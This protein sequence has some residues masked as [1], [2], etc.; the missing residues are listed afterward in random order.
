VLSI[1]IPMRMK[2]SE[3]IKKKPPTRGKQQGCQQNVHPPKSDKLGRLFTAVGQPSERPSSPE[4]SSWIQGTGRRLRYLA[5][6]EKDNI[7]KESF[8]VAWRRVD[9]TGRSNQSNPRRTLLCKPLWRTM[10]SLRHVLRTSH[11]SVSLDMIDILRSTYHVL[12][13]F[14]GKARENAIGINA[15]N[16]LAYLPVADNNADSNEPHQEVE[17]RRGVRGN[18]VLRVEGSPRP[19]LPMRTVVFQHSLELA[20]PVPPKRLDRWQIWS[21]SKGGQLHYIS[22]T[23]I[24]SLR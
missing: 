12:R 16:L 18:G 17:E 10:M 20:E 7:I 3:A 11:G 5:P 24:P 8:R 13:V 9:S 4:L 15:A 2:P 21:T 23:L 22:A 6:L 19:P 14:G 1:P